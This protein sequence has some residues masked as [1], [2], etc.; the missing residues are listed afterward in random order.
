MGDFSKP[1]N[2][3]FVPMIWGL[4]DLSKESLQHATQYQHLL[5]FNEV[6]FY[7]TVASD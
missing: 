1:P 2:A 4:H 5:A 3:E 7:M 6:L